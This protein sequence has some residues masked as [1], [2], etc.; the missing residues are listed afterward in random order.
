M[1]ILFD[2]VSVHDLEVL[3]ICSIR[4]PT[5]CIDDTSDEDTINVGAPGWQSVKHLTLGLGSGRELMFREFNPRIRLSL[6]ARS[7]LGILSL[8]V[9]A[10]PHLYSSSLS[11]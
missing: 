10:P 4:D 5:P 2:E 8:L 11:K 1:L 3:F 6:M 7:L 9:S